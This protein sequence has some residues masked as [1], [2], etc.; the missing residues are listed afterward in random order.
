MAI[1]RAVQNGDEETEES[2]TY[3][4]SRALKGFGN[5]VD[6]RAATA[7]MKACVSIL[8]PMCGWFITAW[9]LAAAL[10]RTLP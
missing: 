9:F 10:I 3:D 8:V 1:R 6:L 7:F 4:R 2:H 5:A